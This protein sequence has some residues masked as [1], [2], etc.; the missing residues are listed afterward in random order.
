MTDRNIYTDTA[1]ESVN[2]D[3]VEKYKE[4]ERF[5]LSIWIAK[6]FSTFVLTVGTIVIAAYVYLTITTHQLVDLT[7]VGS[8]LNGFF[9][10]IKVIVSE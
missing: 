2:T 1:P 5:K 7:T 4:V 10:V 3:K 6:A 9:E 8:F